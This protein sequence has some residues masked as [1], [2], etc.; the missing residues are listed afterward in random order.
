MTCFPFEWKNPC[1]LPRP[2]SLAILFLISV[3]IGLTGCRHRNAARIPPQQLPPEA[4]PG[5]VGQQPLPEPGQQT[6]TIPITPAPPGGVSSTD[7]QFIASHRPV[8]SEVGFATWYTAP[9]KGRKAANGEVFS[10]DALTAAQRTLP[11]GSLIVVTN[12]KTGQSSAM[13][14]TDRGPFVGDRMIDLTIA[15]AKAVGLYRAGL[16]RVR[17]DVYETPKPIYTGGHWSVQIGAFHRE[18]DAMRLKSQLIQLYPGSNVIE[19]PGENSYWVRIRPP[20]DDRK[21]A[22]YIAQHTQPVEGNAYLTRLD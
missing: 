9:Y 3:L 16:A 21:M 18:R 12:L 11:M 15:S 17:M 4:Q 1:G 19:F 13:R 22:E 20:G 7:L 8:L 5:P 6:A 14:I 2:A 10:D